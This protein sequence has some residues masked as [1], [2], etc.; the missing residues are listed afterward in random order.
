LLIFHDGDGQHQQQVILSPY[1]LVKSKIIDIVKK[2]IDLG[3]FE[4]APKPIVSELG[5][6]VRRFS[7]KVDFSSHQ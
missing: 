5:I 6:Y 7:F 1:F 4:S 3:F 2:I